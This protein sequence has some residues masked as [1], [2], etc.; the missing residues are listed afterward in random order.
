[1]VQG[2]IGCVNGDGPGWLGSNAI[3]RSRFCA[4]R[5][6]LESFYPENIFEYFSPENGWTQILGG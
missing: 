3:Q 6:I 4:K 5:E 2:P 1:M